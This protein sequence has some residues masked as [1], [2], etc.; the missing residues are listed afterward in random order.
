LNYRNHEFH[1]RSS[2]IVWFINAVPETIPKNRMR[3]PSRASTYG[4]NR[5][6]EIPPPSSRVIGGK[7]AAKP[8]L[9]ASLAAMDEI[10]SAQVIRIG[11]DAYAAILP[12]FGSKASAVYDTASHHAVTGEVPPALKTRIT[13]RLKAA[14]PS[15]RKVYV[16]AHPDYVER[17]GNFTEQLKAGRPVDGFM[18]DFGPLVNRLFP[19]E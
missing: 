10:R 19:G 17:I 13:D 5:G 4:L 18:Q 3:S 1:I 11:D 12:D 6:G 16:S 15:I 9:G 2:L 7:A 8:E 14:D